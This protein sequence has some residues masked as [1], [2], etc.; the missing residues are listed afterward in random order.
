MGLINFI[1]KFSEI[2]PFNYEWKVEELK[3]E[4]YSKC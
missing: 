2:N 3:D 1:N 4:I